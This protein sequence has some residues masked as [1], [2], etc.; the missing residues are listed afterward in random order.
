MRL[1]L[2]LLLAYAYFP[3][4]DWRGT[5]YRNSDPPNCGSFRIRKI[6]GTVTDQTDGRAPIKDATVEV[7]DDASGKPLWKTATD[8]T[9]RFSINQTWHG[10]LR[11]VFSSPGFLTEDWAV[12]ISRGPDGGFFRSKAMTVVLSVYRGDG[13]AIC[14]SGYSP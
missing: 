12:T 11:V 14:R 3:Q 4:A 2:S 7:F 9:G 10:K 13:I 1:L 6:Q 8:E 5:G